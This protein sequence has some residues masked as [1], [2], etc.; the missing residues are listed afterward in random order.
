MS[1]ENNT[2]RTIISHPFTGYRIGDIIAIDNN[3]KEIDT[4]DFSVDEKEFISYISFLANLIEY[5]NGVAD[6][7]RA[8]H[9]RVEE[10]PDVYTYTNKFID[11]LDKYLISSLR[12]YIKPSE[13][14]VLDYLGIFPSKSSIKRVGNII[15]LYMKNMGLML[16][17]G[18]ETE[19]TRAF[20]NET[21]NSSKHRFALVELASN[22]RNSFGTGEALTLGK[23]G[24]NQ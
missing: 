17:D 7:L 18:S 10:Y 13:K 6:H 8:I 4:T 11:E 9:F 5:Y 15:S 16:V 3:L 23:K 1:K 20:D 19:L 24:K 22:F 14:N 2:E 21:Y 12:N